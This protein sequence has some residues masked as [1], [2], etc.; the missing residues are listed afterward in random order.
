MH[1]Y[2]NCTKCGKKIDPQTGYSNRIGVKKRFCLPC[3]FPDGAQFGAEPIEQMAAI[4]PTAS[5]KLSSVFSIVAGP[6]GRLGTSIGEFR[7]RSRV[8]NEAHEGGKAIH[9]APQ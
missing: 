2:G 6:V 8:A 7:R 3:Q 9:R 4:Q 5:W 1:E